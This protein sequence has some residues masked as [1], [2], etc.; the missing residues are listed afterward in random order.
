[1]YR[2]FPK[3]AWM[4]T[5]HGRQKAGLWDWTTLRT[6]QPN[7]FT[8]KMKEGISSV[9]KCWWR[10]GWQQEYVFEG[11]QE[12]TT[13]TIKSTKEN[14]CQHVP[15]VNS[16]VYCLLFI[17]SSQWLVGS[18]SCND[19]VLKYCFIIKATLTAYAIVPVRVPEHLCTLTVYG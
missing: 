8:V 12:V 19:T 17:L 10:R 5:I 14:I 16:S 18:K 3:R 15:S 4:E 9:F 2:F 11:W 13:G 1:M 7:H 6:I